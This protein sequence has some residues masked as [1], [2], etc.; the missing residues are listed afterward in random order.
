MA[1]WVEALAAKPKFHPQH[2]PGGRKDPGP[3]SCPLTSS[4]VPQYP[5]PPTSH[6]VSVNQPCAWPLETDPPGQNTVRG[7]S[8]GKVLLIQ[9]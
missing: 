6:R 1:Q 3:N 5:Q 2:P 9:A 7:G 4:C 8:A